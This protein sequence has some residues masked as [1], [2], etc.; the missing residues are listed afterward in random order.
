MK[1]FITTAVSVVTMCFFQITAFANGPVIL[2]GTW[3][4]DAKETEK[5]IISTRPF[6]DENLAYSF[7]H[8]ISFLGALISDFDGD[9]LFIGT[10]PGNERKREYI[11]VSHDDA[12]KKYKS[13]YAQDGPKTL[14]ISETLIVNT[15]SKENITIYFSDSAET[16]YLL[17]KHVTLD[18]NKKT[19]NDF[20]P[21]FEAFF[22]MMRNID[23]AYKR[24]N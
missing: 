6:K 20:K 9:K 10:F 19:P 4:I 16:Q 14:E 13:K 7:L 24:P 18:P 17:W 12:E 8:R 21:E 15:Q 5:F 23:K 1:K 2:N 3:I 22:E 11:L